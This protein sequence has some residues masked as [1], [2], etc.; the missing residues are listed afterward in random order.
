MIFN[1]I[2][3]LILLPTNFAKEKCSEEFVC[4][5]R[6]SKKFTI[7]PNGIARRKHALCFQIYNASACYMA[8]RGA[9]YTNRYNV[10]F[11]VGF[12]FVGFGWHIY[13]YYFPIKNVCFLLTY[14]FFA[15]KY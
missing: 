10:S 6:D 7:P 15:V 14:F 3:H 2:P 8:L 5:P 4:E 1:T 12:A 13:F 11:Y 9:L